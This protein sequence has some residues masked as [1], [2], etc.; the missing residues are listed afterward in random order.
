MEI[1]SSS[2]YDNDKELK[3]N[4]A[5]NEQ[6][7]MS[8][9]EATN[10][11]DSLNASNNKFNILEQINT[12]I[13][14]GGDKTSIFIFDDSFNI[15]TLYTNYFKNGNILSLERPED[16]R[17]IIYIGKIISLEYNENLTKI[18]YILNFFEMTNSVLKK[19]KHNESNNLKLSDAILKNS[20][21]MIF[22]SDINEILKYIYTK[23]KQVID[24]DNLPLNN[25]DLN[26]KRTNNLSQ[27]LT[28]N[29][30]K[31]NIEYVKYQE[32]IINTTSI[33]FSNKFNSLSRPILGIYNNK[34][35]KIEI[36][37]YKQMYLKGQEFENELGLISI[38]RNSP[39]QMDLKTLG[40]MTSIF[41]YLY[42]VSEYNTTYHENYSLPTEEDFLNKLL[43]NTDKNLFN[44]SLNLF[45]KTKELIN[46]KKVLLKISNE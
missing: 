6:K 9:W 12:Y 16:L 23:S 24:N 4:I 17:K 27:I 11:F 5:S 20:I 31:G 2:I 21:N 35:N 3:I 34:E 19:V 30:N 45:K 36:L 7:H 25:D 37:N 8:N 18:Q 1:E 15:N 29:Y 13:N 28:N 40:I 22:D 44:L 46:S 33:Q 43:L 32:K 38:K 26:N 39:I 41:K 14:I 10:M 42:V